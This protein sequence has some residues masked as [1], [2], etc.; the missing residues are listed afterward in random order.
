[1]RP[2]VVSGDVDDAVE[3]A[4][5]LMDLRRVLG[6]ERIALW[7][8]SYGTHLAFAT[9]RRHGEHVSRAILA[10]VEGPD[11]TVK[12]PSA[13]QR[14]LEEI[15]RRV[16]D[17]PFAA[18]EFPDLLGSIETLLARLEAEPAR[19]ELLHPQLG[20][21]EVVVC[22][23]DAQRAIAASLR[24]PSRFA[25]LPLAVKRALDGDLDDLAGQIPP[26]RRL[27]LDAM[28]AATDSASGISPDRLAR[29]ERERAGTLLEGAI[30]FPFF[31]VREGLGVEDLGDAFRGPLESDV[32][33]LF[34]SG[35]LDG[36]T[37]P[38]NAE[39]IRSGFRN[40]VHLVLDGAGH[41]DPLFLSSPAIL[42]TML[43]FLRGEPVAD[44]TI[45]LPVVDFAIE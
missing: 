39:E 6:V 40:G 12:L 15:A 26:M 9:L 45:E 24:G 37:P 21:T 23:L 4:D 36:R 44:R 3:S 43:A 32:P 34:I 33:T 16:N 1:M 5:D 17:D 29:F 27:R 14:L 31:A 38:E 19:V 41:G 25:R 10:G 11:H 30:N 13:D 42:E 28:S 20:P 18:E 2:P 35:T 8:I 7:G 22:K